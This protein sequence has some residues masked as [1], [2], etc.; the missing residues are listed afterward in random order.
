MYQWIMG[1]EAAVLGL[2]L[3]ISELLAANPN[4]A[5]NSIFQFIQNAIKGALKPPA[6][7]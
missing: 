1:H 3:A 7:S 5:A 6:Q 4:V 2:L